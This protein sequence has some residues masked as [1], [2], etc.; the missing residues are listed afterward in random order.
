MSSNLTLS[1]KKPDDRISV[2]GI[3][4]DKF[5]AYDI[6]QNNATIEIEDL[7]PYGEVLKLAEEAPLLRA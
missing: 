5:F 6:Q 4:S 3:R 2:F 1:A 7:W